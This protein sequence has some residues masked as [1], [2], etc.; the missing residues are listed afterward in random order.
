MSNTYTQHQGFG[1]ATNNNL[2]VVMK[3]KAA[4]ALQTPQQGQYLPA[5]QADLHAPINRPQF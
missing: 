5:A 3:L 1:D 2:S 4:A